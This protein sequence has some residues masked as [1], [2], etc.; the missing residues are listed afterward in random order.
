MQ[1]TPKQCPRA[2]QHSQACVYVCVC[3]SF[4]AVSGH[5]SSSRIVHPS[6]QQLWYFWKPPPAVCCAS[7]LPFNRNTQKYCGYTNF[8]DFLKFSFQ[9][10]SLLLTAPVK[11]SGIC[12]QVFLFFVLNHCFVCEAKPRL[13]PDSHAHNSIQPNAVHLMAAVVQ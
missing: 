2:E 11:D 9:S 3:L 5:S 6:F 13:R 4:C 1:E 7:S 10:T 12:L 8:V